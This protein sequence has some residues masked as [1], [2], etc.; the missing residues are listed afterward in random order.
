MVVVDKEPIFSDSTG[1]YRREVKPG[2]PRIAAKGIGLESILVKR[3]RIRRGDSI[4]INFQM[5]SDKVPLYLQTR[6]APKL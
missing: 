4:Q 6:K 1:N 2:T 3:L 5:Q